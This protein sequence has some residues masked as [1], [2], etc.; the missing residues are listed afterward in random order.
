MKIFRYKVT[1]NDKVRIVSI[2][3]L[4]KKDY[5]ITIVNAEPITTMYCGYTTKFN[6]SVIYTP[7]KL[8][9]VDYSFT[10][11]IIAPDDKYDARIEIGRLEKRM[12]DGKHS[13]D[14]FNIPITFYSHGATRAFAFS[15]CVKIMND[16]CRTRNIDSKIKIEDYKLKE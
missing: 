7:N 3:V 6:M 10:H 12:R 8:D 14:N 9:I 1:I 2:G 16:W 15:Y 4:V 5:E 11:A 13:D